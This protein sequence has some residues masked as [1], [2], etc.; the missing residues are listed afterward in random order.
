[1]IRKL[2]K[3]TAVIL[4][5]VMLLTSGIALLG[6]NASIYSSSDLPVVYVQG[7][8]SPMWTNANDPTSEQVW[9]LAINE[10]FL[11][12]IVNDLLP[13]LAW[14]LTYDEWDTYCDTFY[15]GV[16]A[17]YTEVK[18]DVD[19]TPIVREDGT[20]TGNDCAQTTSL[21]ANKK[22][23][24]SVTEYNFIYD[25]RESPLDVADDLNNYIQLVKEATG[26]S[27][28][29]IVGRCLGA[30][31]VLAYLDE[32]GADDINCCSLYSAG[33]YGFDLIEAIFT[34]KM[35]IT[36]TTTQ[37][38]VHNITDDGSLEIEAE[39]L[40][41]LLAL[42]NVTLAT[43]T[44]DS[45]LDYIQ[46]IYDKVYD[47]IIPRI[48]K[49]SYATWPGYWSL[50][51]S[52]CFDEAMDFV[53]SAEGDKETY[54]AVIEKA[55]EYK[56]NIMDKTTE[57]LDEAQANGVKVQIVAKYGLQAIPFI[58]DGSMQSDN[59]VSTVSSSL[60]A[61]CSAIDKTLS[62]EYISSLSTTKYVSVDK[63][64]DASTCY[65]PDS[66]WFVKNLAHK[67]FPNDVNKLFATFFRS[68][69]T[70]TVS[71]DP[72]WPQYL[73]YNINEDTVTIL[74]QDI[75]DTKDSWDISVIESFIILIKKFFAE[76]AAFFE[77][78]FG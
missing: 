49:D 63:K 40:E 34:G 22:A 11:T 64:I 6:A 47:N 2:K 33:F 77:S 28:V 17:L 9:P 65:L 75:A 7:Y 24:Y 41:T 66:T 70:M 48:L 19:G 58:E 31:I 3:T 26:H 32:Y 56:T 57:I 43:N 61:T 14:G 59:T 72:D 25:W 69:G 27:K 13:H 45:G 8:G 46:I 53:F 60:G 15:K 78:I 16:A 23:S 50:I 68:N 4:T 21:P 1:M 39:T 20:Y 44:L 76:I 55:S 12:G 35:E 71:S 38:Y 36:G 29:N 62:D 37:R 51:G 74:T 52:D 42:I 5:V 30:N 67:T 10:E 18:Y 54:A 73:Y